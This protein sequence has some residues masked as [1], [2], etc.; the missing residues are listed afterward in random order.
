MPIASRAGM[1]RHGDHAEEW[2]PPCPAPVGLRGCRLE[3]DERN[4]LVMSFPLH[5]GSALPTLTAAEHDVLRLVL[6]GA[7]NAQVARARGSSPR[8]VANQLASIFR[9]AGVF[10]RSTLALRCAAVELGDELPEEAR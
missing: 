6:A 4:V 9:K 2:V 7:S 5:R 3:L 8:T 1:A 10:S